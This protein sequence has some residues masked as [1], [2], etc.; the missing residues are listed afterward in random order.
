[1]QTERR[2]DGEVKA[3]L[4]GDREDE[5]EREKRDEGSEAHNMLWGRMRVPTR[6]Q[7]YTQDEEHD[8]EQEQAVW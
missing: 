1:M 6:K 7:G 3:W 2:G 4:G 8:G 5:G